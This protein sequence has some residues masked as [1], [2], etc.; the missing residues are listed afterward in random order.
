ME[1]EKLETKAQSRL[2]EI[3]E[4]AKNLGTYPG[5]NWDD[6]A[7]DISDY[8][9]PQAH[10]KRRLVLYFTSRRDDRSDP[11]VPYEQPFGDFA[12]AIIRT[13]ASERGLS[14]YGH[15]HIMIALRY[16]YS[17]LQRMGLSDPTKLTRKHFKIAIADARQHAAGW[18]IYHI[19]RSLQEIATWLDDRELTNVRLSFKNPVESP[20]NGDG[21]DPE[22]QAKG[23]L[24][25]PSAAALDALADISNN[26][27]NDDE[28]ILLRII[29]LLVVGGF[30]IGETLNLPVDCWVEAPALENNGKAK[31]DPTS[32]EPIM[33]YG[34]RYRPEKGG[35]PYVKWL[36]DIALPVAR[37]AVDDLTR[38]CSE[39]RAAAK[40]LEENPERV[41]L[42]GSLSPDD[43]LDVKQVA[44]IVGLKC[45]D[46]ARQF[47]VTSLSLK[48][49]AKRP[50]RGPSAL[51]FRVS[52]IERALLKRR[53]EIVVTR[54][55]GG[56]V[57]MLSESL[58]VMFHY[59]FNAAR[60]MFKFLP[61]L[62]GEGQI[63]C[64]LGNDPDEVSIFSIRGLTEPDGSLMRI[65]THAFR[66]WL[67]TILA[68]GGL[69]D[70][71]L[72][73][74]SGRRNPDQNAAYKHGTVE[75]RVAWAQEMIKEGQLQ[76]PVADTYHAIEDPVE[77]QEFLKTFVNVALFTPYGVCVHDYAIDPCPHHLNC[78]GGCSEYLRTKGDKEEQ[79]NIAAVY[80]FHLVQ[81]QRA[82]SAEKDGIAEAGNY[83]AHCHRMVEGAKAALAV[84]E[85]S[86]PDGKLVKVFPNGKR[87]GTAIK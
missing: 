53:R 11:Q 16:L 73:R 82:R 81:L 54:S 29:D 77:K 56:Q 79:K 58:C 74:W 13:R 6:F 2:K 72:A 50:G 18:T 25:M 23:L 65:K 41:P 8:E 4:E 34:I 83:A 35:A 37:R 68:R 26:P 64:A 61:E 32:G 42:P 44:T 17:S 36:S 40:V 14:H 10:R 59:Q 31:T 21:L 69:S 85:I 55:P 5:I 33:R 27:L 57:Q 20:G 39:A 49:V 78:L 7:W 15:I 19:G 52:D 47:L 45:G 22:S 30:R 80:E 43:L 76:G 75:Q 28:R 67:N 62:I 51:L 63:N 71:E 12:K 38:L 48:P 66:H 24:K 84:D 86:D 46:S 3:V 70:I 9:K 1:A 87:L 60:R